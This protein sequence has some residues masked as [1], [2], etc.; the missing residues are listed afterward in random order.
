LIRQLKAEVPKTP[1][2]D[3]KIKANVEILKKL[4]AELIAEL[5]KP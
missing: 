4:K 2:L 3:I 1:E 5:Q